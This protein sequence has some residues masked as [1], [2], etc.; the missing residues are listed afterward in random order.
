MRF[1]LRHL[2][3]AVAATLALTLLVSNLTTDDKKIEVE[4]R[5]PYAARDPQFL[6]SMGVLLGPSI[7]RGN[8][9]RHLEN[10]DEIF[11]AMLDAIRAA[12]TTITFET[13][14]YWSGEVGRRFADALRERARAGVKVH[15][16]L[17]W[18][19]SSKMDDSLLQAMRAD[20]VQ[21]AR[22]HQ[23]KWYNL[24]RLNNRTHRKLLV[25]DGRVAFTG[26]VGIA[27][28]W[29]G[30]AQDENHWRDS[31]FRVEGPV[32][33]QFQAVFMDNWVQATGK[34]LHTPDYF[35]EIEN[36]GDKAA[37]MFSSGPSGGSE[38]MH[39]MYLLAIASSRESILLSSSYFVPDE[40]AIGALVEAAKRGVRIRIITP[41]DKI[42]TE[43]VR[44]ASRARWGDLLKAGIGIYE[45]QP[46]MFHCKV[47]IV[48][49][50]LVSTGSTNFD[51]RSFRL[52]DEANLNVYDPAFAAE[53]AKVFEDDVKHARQVTLEQWEG[54]PWHEKLLEQALSLIGQQL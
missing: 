25:V 34:V 27:D 31:H 41:G 12:R 23:P 24:S 35:P 21:V 53:M 28:K 49:G 8:Q 29:S 5:S 50:F 39:L 19:G 52:N 51:N 38:S 33:L 54:R 46:T 7:V 43:V 30:N 20:G 45:Y 15:V 18:V 37:Q 13:Y 40:L 44:R 32:A 2:L 48:D 22:Y 14:I 26:G 6:R 47:M 3:F 11:P 36:A 1:R 10:G 42:D 16:L 4:V 17:D 9:V